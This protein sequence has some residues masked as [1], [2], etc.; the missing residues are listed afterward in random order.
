MEDSWIGVN[1]YSKE[2]ILYTIMK[3]IWYFACIKPIELYSTENLKNMTIES[4]AVPFVY[5]VESSILLYYIFNKFVSITA[6]DAE[7]YLIWRIM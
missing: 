7:I 5:K 3:D 1:F 4:D 2:N 6:R